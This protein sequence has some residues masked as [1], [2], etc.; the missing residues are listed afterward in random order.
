M[1]QQFKFFFK[2]YGGSRFKWSWLMLLFG[3][4]DQ[5]GKVPIH[6]ESL[7]IYLLYFVFNCYQR[8]NNFNCKQCY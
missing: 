6:S 2:Y 1:K 8:K 4:H 3:L 7:I 5:S